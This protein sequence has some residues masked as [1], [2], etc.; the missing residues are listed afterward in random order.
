ML[1]LPRRPGLD[2][3]DLQEKYL[4]L[5]AR[6][7]PDAPTGDGGKF[8]EL[9]EARKTLKDPA[10]RLRHL[11][12]LEGYEN[13]PGGKFQPPADLFLEV[14]EALEAAKRI[15]ARLSAAP[16]SLARALLTGERVAV[17]RKI[18]Q[19]MHDLAGHR[20][21]CLAQISECDARWPE[22][23]LPHLDRIRNE[24]VYLIRWENELRERGFLLGNPPAP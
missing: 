20:N 16:S 4:R 12:D 1:G 18:R 5:A 10:A 7:H 3:A 24:M 8:R 6:W 15:A 19:V 17:E 11:L 14:A 21:R 22:K 9:Q 23:N 13:P 2:E